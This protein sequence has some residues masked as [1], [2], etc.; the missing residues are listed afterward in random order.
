MPFEVTGAPF[1]WEEGA[2]IY[3]GSDPEWKLQA[4]CR[5]IPDRRIFFSNHPSAMAEAKRTCRRCVV[6]TECLQYA[7]DENIKHGTFG[8]MTEGERLKLK[9]T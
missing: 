4:L 6:C 7:L 8:G 9:N 5:K 1:W 2:D 3:F